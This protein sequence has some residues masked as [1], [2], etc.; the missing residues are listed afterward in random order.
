LI[1]SLG[2]EERVVFSVEG[3]LPEGFEKG[4]TGGARLEVRGG[5]M[6]VHGKN[7]RQVPLVSEVVSLLGTQG[8]HFNDLHTE[9]P[10]LEDVFLSLTGREMRE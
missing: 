3:T 2:A 5:Q 7:G 9:Q 8:V 1:R 10:N 6:V 4:L